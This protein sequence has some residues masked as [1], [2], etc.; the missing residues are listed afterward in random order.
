[1]HYVTIKKVFKKL[2]YKPT[3]SCHKIVKI[4]IPR[5]IFRKHGLPLVEFVQGDCQVF[6]IASNIHNFGSLLH[7]VLRKKLEW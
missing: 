5:V 1:M 4:L 7:D 6:G 3:L 2:A